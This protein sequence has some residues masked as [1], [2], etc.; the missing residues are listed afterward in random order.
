MSLPKEFP[1]R[2]TYELTPTGKIGLSTGESNIRTAQNIPLPGRINVQRTLVR[3]LP[4]IH[5]SHSTGPRVALAQYVLSASQI[6]ASINKTALI[7]ERISTGY[8]WPTTGVINRMTRNPLRMRPSSNRPTARWYR[9]TPSY[10]RGEEPYRKTYGIKI[11]SS[12]SLMGSPMPS[13]EARFTTSLQRDAQ[14]N[15]DSFLLVPLP[16]TP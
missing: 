4:V 8:R 10:L 13:S 12:S 2:L 16:C 5:C 15:Y 3:N 11:P 14:P 7:A 9:L 1:T 6:M